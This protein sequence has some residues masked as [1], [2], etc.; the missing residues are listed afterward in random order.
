MSTAALILAAGKGE[1][2][3]HAIPK[4]FVSLRGTTLLV[5][6]L[7]AMAAV[8]EIDLVVPVVP[9][10]DHSHWRE[11]A[12][13]GE[14]VVGSPHLRAKL[15][16]PVAGGA[17]RQDSGAA[18]LAALP[19]SIAWVA[20][21]DAARCLVASD[22]VAEVIRSAQQAGGGGAA[23]LAQPARDT[24]KRVRAGY[25]RE[26]PPRDE[27]WVAQTPQVFRVELLR[28]ALAKAEAEGVLG[29]DD[30]QLVE[31]LGVEVRVVASHSPNWKI[32]GPEDLANAERWLDRGAGS[33]AGE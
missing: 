13:E 33:S 15:A 19:A 29:T 21:H 1:R 4:A 6:S 25:I 27:C 14:G 3:G 24:I 23:I 10:G 11:L 7:E 17:R 30:A 5:R 28:E 18:G 20:V 12:G 26:T 22:D 2:L 8:A 16:E 9:P 31:R 32:T